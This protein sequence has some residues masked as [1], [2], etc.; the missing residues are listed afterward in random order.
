M[1]TLPFSNAVFTMHSA[2]KDE[3]EHELESC[4]RSHA[5]CGVML[6]KIPSEE[7]TKN[8]SLASRVCQPITSGSAITPKSNQKRMKIQAPV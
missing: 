7:T 5:S 4:I 8:L 6:S 2:N 3:G 1:S